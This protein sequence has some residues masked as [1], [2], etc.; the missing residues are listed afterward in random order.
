[1]E[2]TPS[3]CITTRIH[4]HLRVH[5][6]IMLNGPERARKS[7]RNGPSSTH[8]PRN[9]LDGPEAGSDTCPQ[10][11]RRARFARKHAGWTG[12][13]S[14]TRLP[15]GPSCTL[16]TRTCYMGQN[17]PRGASLNLPHPCCLFE[18]FLCNPRQK[19]TCRL[20]TRLATGCLIKQ[21]TRAP[22][23]GETKHPTPKLSYD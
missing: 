9:V 15:N 18:P 16:G 19:L 17:M 3:N 1:M 2:E 8:D 23:A 14:W 6:S 10:V 22:S 20:P 21:Q 5:R 12:V 13:E 4:P 11:T 7:T